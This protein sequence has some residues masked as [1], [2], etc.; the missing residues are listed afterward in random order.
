MSCYVFV[1]KASASEP[2]D[3]E[4]EKEEAS[5]QD[6]DESSDDS[7][8]NEAEPAPVRTSHLLR[9]GRRTVSRPRRP[10]CR[11]TT[12]AKRKKR[13]KPTVSLLADEKV[14]VEVV[15]TKTMANVV[16][17]RGDLQEN[18]PST[19]LYPVLHLDELEFFPGD[20]VNDKRGKT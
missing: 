7:D 11:N 14:C 4:A 6:A 12:A 19:E 13:F 8:D 3:K 17:Q 2:V 16:W 20:F 10:P 1:A 9:G 5:K 15:L 18:I